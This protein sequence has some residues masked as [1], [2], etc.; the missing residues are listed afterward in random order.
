M[1]PLRLAIRSVRLE[2]FSPLQFV[3]Q[4]PDQHAL[5]CQLDHAIKAERRA[6]IVIQ[7]TVSHSRRDAF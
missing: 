5:R 2:N 1:P 4:T 3:R 6:S 7:A